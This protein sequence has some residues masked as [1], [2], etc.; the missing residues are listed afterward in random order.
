MTCKQN[1]GI[2]AIRGRKWKLVAGNESGGREP[3]TGN[4]FDAPPPNASVLGTAPAEQT[5]LL[6][7]E[8]EVSAQLKRELLRV[9]GKDS[10]PSIPLKWYRFGA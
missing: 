4:T 1:S 7:A 10:I 3:P 9:E 2:F 6:D 8:S 5:N